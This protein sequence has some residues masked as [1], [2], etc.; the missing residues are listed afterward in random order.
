MLSYNSQMSGKPKTPP[1]EESLAE[2]VEIIARVERAAELDIA[3]RK[4]E[5][6]IE[7]AERK[8]ERAAERAERKAEREIEAKERA[9]ERAER[10]VERAERKAEREREAKE[11]AAERAERKAERAAERAERKAERIA[12]RAERKAEYEREAKERAAERAERDAERKKDAAALDARLKK[13]EA[14]SKARYERMEEQSAKIRGEWGSHTSD[15]GEELEDQVYNALDESK[16]IGD[17]RLDRVDQ[18]LRNVVD[19]KSC[20]YD[21]VAENG[22]VTVV[23]E[24]KHKLTL[25]DVRRFAKKHLPLFNQAFPNLARGRD[26]IGAMAYESI[27][28]RKK[29]VQEALDLG[30]LLLHAEGKKGLRQVKSVADSGRPADRGK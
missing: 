4:A 7:R 1:V 6:E 14:A 28:E 12:E 30:L 27:R 19:G 15:E 11:R 22:K 17:I 13:E 24:V 5:R 29:T 9:T 8:A 21:I 3:E 18:K 20:E 25:S 26:V 16:Q 10:E 23:L 2:V